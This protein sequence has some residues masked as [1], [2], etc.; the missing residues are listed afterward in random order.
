MADARPVFTNPFDFLV[1]YKQRVYCS[2]ERLTC[3][4]K[5]AGF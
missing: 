1:A 3:V 2:G 5:I 4:G